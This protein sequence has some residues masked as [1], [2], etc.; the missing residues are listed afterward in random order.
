VDLEPH[1]VVDLPGERSAESFETW[2][3]DHPAVETVNRDRCGLYAESASRGAPD[4]QQ[5]AD[6]FHLVL[7]L[8]AAVERALEERRDQLEFPRRHETME[9][10]GRSTVI[11]RG[12]PV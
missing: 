6:R 12:R 2:L 5:I 9:R 10:S 7:N 8:S 11:G 1:R 4:T 3:K